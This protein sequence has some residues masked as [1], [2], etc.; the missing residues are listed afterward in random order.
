M[1]YVVILC[2]G[3][4]DYPLKNLMEKLHWSMRIH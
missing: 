1:K 2:D 4:A 3:M